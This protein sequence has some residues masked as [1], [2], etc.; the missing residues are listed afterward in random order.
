VR[1]LKE[2]VSIIM[3]AY[4]EAGH[5]SL[6]IGETAKTFNDF[7]CP[8]EL[9]VIDDGSTDN[10]FEIATQ[11]ALNYP[12]QVIIKKNPFNLGKGRAIK[13]A[14]HY[15]TGEYVVFLDADMDLHPLQVQTLFDI[16]RLDN[17]DIVIGS[18]LHPNSVVDYPLE[19][20][21]VSFFYYL[22][23]RV[24]FNLPCHD[25][26]TGL[27][28]FKAEVVRK[29]FPRILV[30]QFAYDLEVLANAHHLGYRIAEAPIVLRQQRKYARIGSSAVISTLI[31]TLAV[32]YRMYILK[33]YDN[34][35][36]YRRKGMAKELRR[37][38][39]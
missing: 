34:I 33:Y 13:K 35:D 21:V 19:R 6:S 14:V 23:V 17:A 39:R 28:L 31:D 18:K 12:G 15:I 37:M 32:F 1:N 30:R 2:K 29:V 20:R 7:G 4:N 9:I 26:Q 11:V 5:I 8:W 38:R 27:K 3:P 36:Y 24:L 25:T 10:T 22:L 16:M